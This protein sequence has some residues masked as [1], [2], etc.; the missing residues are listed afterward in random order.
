MLLFVI[1]SI[2]NYCT[3]VS[4]LW[5]Y[6]SISPSCKTT[7]V[8]K[9]FYSFFLTQWVIFFT[10]WTQSKCILPC[11]ITRYYLYRNGHQTDQQDLG[12]IYTNMKRAK[13]KGGNI[14]YPYQHQHFIVAVAI[15]QRWVKTLRAL[16]VRT[17]SYGSRIN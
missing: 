4:L 9:Y 7:H 6:V 17:G 2:R 1:N 10:S 8:Q 3:L 16:K 14:E 13:F 12:H 5:K 15:T 11:A